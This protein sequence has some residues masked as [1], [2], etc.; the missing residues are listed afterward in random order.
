M[1]LAYLTQGY[2]RV[3]GY[4]VRAAEVSGFTSLADLRALHH[5]DHEGSLHPAAGPVHVLHVDRSPVWQLHPAPS[6]RVRERPEFE[7][8]G[9]VEVRDQLVEQQFLDHTRLTRGARLWRFEAGRDPLLVGTY[10]GPA[11]GWQDHTR[12]GVVTA[13]VPAPTTGAVVLLGEEAF[14]AEVASDDDGRPE[15][16]TAVAASEPAPGLGFTRQEG[17]RFWTRAVDHADARALFEVR[18]TGSHLGLPVQVTQQFRMPD[19]TIRARVASLARDWERA[20]DAGFLELELGVWE[21][22]VPLSEVADLTPHE[23]T[24][25]AWM[26]KWQQDRVAALRQRAAQTPAAE[27]GPPAAGPPA[28]GPGDQRHLELYQRIARAV[29]PALPAGATACQILCQ[30]VGNVMELSAQ[31]ILGDESPVALPEVDAELG[32]AFAELRALGARSEEGPWFGVLLTIRANGEVSIRFNRSDR[33]RLRRDI[34][35]KML[36]AERAR[37]PRDAYPGWFTELERELG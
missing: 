20:R 7:T 27:G 16:I 22:D 2:D 18:V 11:L 34:T 3:A 28:A 10:L 9:I 31:A 1:A 30:S 33:P 37:F 5:L 23:L 26:T 19:G 13:T 15:A 32:R 14:V 29:V 6:D 8:S 17:A 12:D 25:A 4:V 36:R 35:G 24:S 21:K